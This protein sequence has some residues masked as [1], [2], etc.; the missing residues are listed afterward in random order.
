MES[1]SIAAFFVAL[2]ELVLAEWASCHT[3]PPVLVGELFFFFDGMVGSLLEP[4][5]VGCCDFHMN[6]LGMRVQKFGLFPRTYLL[7]QIYAHFVTNFGRFW[8][9]VRHLAL[10]P[11]R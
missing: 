5:A 6:S 4:N 11:F 1:G 9:S 8:V 2:L 3:F 7:L 10:S